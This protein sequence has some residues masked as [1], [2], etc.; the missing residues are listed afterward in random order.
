MQNIGM[1]LWN[2]WSNMLRNLGTLYS[3][4]LSAWKKKGHKIL[5]LNIAPCPIWFWRLWW[6]PVDVIQKLHR[7]LAK[8]T[9]TQKASIQPAKRLFSTTRKMCLRNLDVEDVYIGVLGA[10]ELIVMSGVQALLDNGDEILVSL[11]LPTMDSVFFAFLGGTPS[12]L[13][14]W[15]RCRLVSRFRRHAC[16]RS[17]QRLAA[18]FFTQ[19]EQTW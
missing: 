10:S 18:S 11:R 9:A 4:M 3:N 16:G 19:S 13:H 7:H 5:K 6:N 8:V 2:Q 12:S 14:V 15:W 17:H 1:S